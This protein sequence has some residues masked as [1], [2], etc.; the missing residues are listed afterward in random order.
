[1]KRLLNSQVPN[2][3]V[4]V[5]VKPVKDKPNVVLATGKT[6]DYTGDALKA[7]FEWFK[8][9]IGKEKGDEYHITYEG[10]E[11]VLKMVRKEDV[12]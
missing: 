6:E 8:N 7:V 2:K 3:I 12:E 9:N 4:L 10:E 5:N 1:M 11:F